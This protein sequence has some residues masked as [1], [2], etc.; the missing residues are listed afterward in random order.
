VQRPRRKLGLKLGALAVWLVAATLAARWLTFDP[1]AQAR[2][3]VA[4]VNPLVETDVAQLRALA[5]ASSMAQAAAGVDRV[6]VG[7]LSK[8]LGA[9]QENRRAIRQR[10]HHGPGPCA[11]YPNDTD[12]PADP[13]EAVRAIVS[14]GLAARLEEL[15]RACAARQAD[16]DDGLH[17]GDEAS[18]IVRF[19]SE[20]ADPWTRLGVRLRGEATLAAA[21]A[22]M[23]PRTAAPFPG[24]HAREAM[25]L[26]DTYG[27]IVTAGLRVTEWKQRV[28]LT[29][30]ELHLLHP[31]LTKAEVRERLGEPKEEGGEWVYPSRNARVRFDEGGRVAGIES[32]IPSF[33][34]MVFAGEQALPNIDRE[35]LV[36]AL[37]APAWKGDGETLAASGSDE[38]LGYDRGPYALALSFQGGSLKSVELRKAR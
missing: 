28:D 20:Q 22:L 29:A 24:A 37:G 10:Y 23:R 15:T 7:S 19:F 13:N 34:P 4:Q 12:A 38:I 5:Q 1:A 17:E 35:S 9:A 31:D 6:D 25:A 32:R 26:C 27:S 3:F 2:A 11:R 36:A 21:R 18:E 33:H 14:A 30:G 16:R 8:R